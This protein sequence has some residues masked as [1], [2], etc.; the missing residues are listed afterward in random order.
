[1]E[2]VISHLQVDHRMG[3]NYLNGQAGDRAN[4]LL[5]AAG[6][7]FSLL[8]RWFEELLCA[9]LA[10][11]TRLFKTPRPA[12]NWARKHSSEAFSTDMWRACSSAANQ[13]I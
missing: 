5:A 11:L 13:R 12:Q 6:Y 1:V 2:T 3:R 8:L 10:E 4:A 7:N 9:L